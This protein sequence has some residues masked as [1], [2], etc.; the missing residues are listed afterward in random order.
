MTYTEIMTLVERAPLEEGKLCRIY[1]F[2]GISDLHNR[3]LDALRQTICSKLNLDEA[4]F[5]RALQKTYDKWSASIDKAEVR[6]S[7]LEWVD[8]F[9]D[10]N[11]SRFSEDT[12]SFQNAESLIIHFLSLALQRVSI[13]T[14]KNHLKAKDIRILED[15]L[16]S[17]KYLKKSSRSFLHPLEDVA[18]GKYSATS[19]EYINRTLAYAQ[20]LAYYYLYFILDGKGARTALCQAW[21]HQMHR[22]SL[23]EVRYFLDPAPRSENL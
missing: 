17:S 10:E 8:D 12:L 7:A 1:M 4:G 15:L 3:Q 2:A 11:R 13:L 21:M 23:D 20:L 6:L 16:S 9:L 5:S 18:A 19:T 14:Y 22:L